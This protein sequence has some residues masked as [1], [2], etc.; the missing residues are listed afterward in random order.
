MGARAR[1]GM[2]AATSLRLTYSTFVRRGVLGAS[3][4]FFPGRAQLRVLAAFVGVLSLSLLWI[5]ASNVG[6]QNPDAATSSRRL[7]RPG[8]FNRGHIRAR[9]D[10]YASKHGLQFG[11]PEHGFSSAISQ[12]HAMEAS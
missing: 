8:Q 5:A 3:R 4:R 6:A 10:Y 11:T 2:K 9:D 1:G 7:R 12:M